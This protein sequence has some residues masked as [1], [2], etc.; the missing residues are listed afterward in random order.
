MYLFFKTASGNY[1]TYEAIP[2]QPDSCINYS[3]AE[4]QFGAHNSS[5]IENNIKRIEF[6]LERTQLLYLTPKTT[7]IFAR[8]K[9]SLRKSGNIIDDFDILIGATAIEN[10]LTLVT[11]NERHFSRIGKIRM[12]NWLE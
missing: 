12:V 1:K 6:F 10:D 9:A 3:L 5:Q 2:C 7:N 8:I 11:N 4:L